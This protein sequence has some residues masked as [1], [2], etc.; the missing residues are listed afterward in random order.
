MLECGAI[1]SHCTKLTSIPDSLFDGF[2]NCKRFK[3]TFRDC[4]GIIQVPAQ[5]FHKC[6]K[7][8]EFVRVFYGT[9]IKVSDVPS[10]FFRYNKPNPY[11]APVLG[12]TAG[13]TDT[14]TEGDVGAHWRN[15][16]ISDSSG[17]L[18]NNLIFIEVFGT[19]NHD[20][21]YDEWL[22]YQAREGK[23]RDVVIIAK[24]GPGNKSNSSILI[25]NYGWKI[26]QDANQWL[27]LYG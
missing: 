6:K 17:S 4:S 1:F 5:L 3:N 13:T 19:Q 26:A 16:G 21:L 20:V 24:S 15:Y 8:G 7:A 25:P 9:G 2:V 11:K 23:C 18:K 12:N 14:H 22:K 27:D 10:D